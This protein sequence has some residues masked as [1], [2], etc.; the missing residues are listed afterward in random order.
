MHIAEG[1]LSA[2]ALVTGG[3]LAAGGVAAGLQTM[4]DD[5]IPQT[6][7]LTT[8][9]FVASLIHVPLGPSSVHLM[10]TGLCGLL[11]GWRAFPALLIA[12]F[13]Q[14][15]L[16]GFGGLLVLGAN[17]VILAGPAVAVGLPLRRWV[18]R[19]P[20][21]AS[22]AGAL[23][24]GLSILGSALLAA[25]SLA[26]SHHSFRG[27]AALLLAGSFPLMILEG[28]ITAGLVHFLV[29]IRPELLQ[30][31]RRNGAA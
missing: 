1:I 10:L 29:R 21:R 4:R 14:A 16:F 27:V 11:L 9:F 8:V 12:L 3:V 31:T 17:T 13:L 18:A 22:W 19:R 15:V 24:G 5:E 25:G 28:I 30:G 7:L 26:W 6:A 2:P 20:D 23:A